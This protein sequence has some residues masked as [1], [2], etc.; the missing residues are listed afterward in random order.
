MTGANRCPIGRNV[1]AEDEPYDSAA[2]SKFSRTQVG[3]RMPQRYA[4]SVPS[5]SVLILSPLFIVFYSGDLL[6]S[7][8]IVLE[9]NS[10]VLVQNLVLEL[11]LGW[12]SLDCWN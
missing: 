1:Y 6:Y 10:K 11:E 7:I 4:S 8:P 9:F 12:C 5:R 3:E 2:R